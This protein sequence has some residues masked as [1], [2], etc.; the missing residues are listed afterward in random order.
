MLLLHWEKFSKV[1]CIVNFNGTLRSELT[2]ENLLNLAVSEVGAA[3][4]LLQVA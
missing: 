1:S 3:D 4:T 2:F